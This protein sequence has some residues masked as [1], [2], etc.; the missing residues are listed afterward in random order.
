VL[1]SELA[2]DERLAVGLIE[3]GQQPDGVRVGLDGPG[4]LVLS[5]DPPIGYSPCS[6]GNMKRVP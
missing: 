5:L 4:A 2:D 1:A 6:G 3:G